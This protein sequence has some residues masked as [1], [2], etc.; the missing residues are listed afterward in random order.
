M[1]F[2]DYVND[3]YSSLS[4]QSA[5]A[6]A[7]DDQHSASGDFNSSKDQQGGGMGTAQQSRGATTRGGVS[8]AT[9]ASGTDEESDSEAEINKQD[10]KGPTGESDP[11]HKPG[12]GGEGS[13]Q[14]GAANAGPHGGPVGKQSDDDDEEESGG[15]DDEE[16]E[17]EDEPVDPMPKIEEGEHTSNTV[18]PLIIAIISSEFAWKW[19]VGTS[20]SP[21][22]STPTSPGRIL[23]SG[24]CQSVML[25]FEHSLTLYHRL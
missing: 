24:L 23:A 2:F 13:G 6:D 14:L 17:D 5:Y 12:D 10:E 9:P 21:N 15:D 19:S 20:N 7:S 1:G 8:T 25:V 16:E 3:L 18:Y 11:G 22:H 4:V